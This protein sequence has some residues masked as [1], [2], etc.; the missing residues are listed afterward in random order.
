MTEPAREGS[1]P[2]GADGQAVNVF[3]ITRAIR[4][5]ESKL[6]AGEQVFLLEIVDRIELGGGVCKWSTEEMCDFLGVSHRHGRRMTAKFAWESLIE[7]TRHGM[8][9]SQ[10]SYKSIRLGPKLLDLAREFGK[11]DWG[12]VHPDTQ[13]RVQPRCTLTPR[14]VHPDTQVRAPGHPRPCTLTCESGIMDSEEKEEKQTPCIPPSIDTKPGVPAFASTSAAQ[15][16]SDFSSSGKKMPQ[17]KTPR[18]TARDLDEAIREEAA[19]NGRAP[20]G[21]TPIDAFGSSTE[22]FEPFA[23]EGPSDC[24][25]GSIR[26]AIT[27]GERYGKDYDLIEEELSNHPSNRPELIPYIKAEVDKAR[28][29]AEGAARKAMG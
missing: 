22:E 25:I 27:L 23:S 12:D 9:Q 16:V 26:K 19:D 7:I 8:S 2:P 21:R 3:H 5:K 1:A 4:R 6:N 11:F 20:G 13:V 17:S 28:T 15:T 29:A 18:P 24:E 10:F 14:S